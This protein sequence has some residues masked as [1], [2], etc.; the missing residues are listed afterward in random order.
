MPRAQVV[1]RK[2]IFV[3]CEGDGERSYITLVQ[4]IVEGIH[5]KV[6]LDPHLLQP[7]GG[8]PLDLCR[9]AEEVLTRLKRT[10]DPYKARYLL[11]DRDKLGVSPQRD[12]QMSAILNRIGTQIIYQ[13]PAREALILRHL[14]S[15]AN[16]RPGSTELAMQQLLQE[17]PEYRKNMS[18]IELA[19]KLD[20]ASLRQAASV[21]NELRAFF[22]MIELL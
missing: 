22:Q 6:Y 17:W 5:H 3:G 4:R 9:R 16:R 14:Q 8:D 2:R 7:G 20:L 15:C 21:E 1:R 12:A 19:R 13:E 18:A 10:R 11:I